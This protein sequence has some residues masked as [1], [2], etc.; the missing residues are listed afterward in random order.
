MS[1]WGVEASE[2]GEMSETGE[3]RWESNPVHVVPFAHVSRVTHHATWRVT[4]IF[5]N[6]LEEGP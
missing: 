3:T 4:D 5:S 1:E 2:T 6:L